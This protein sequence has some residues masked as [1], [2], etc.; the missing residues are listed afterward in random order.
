L[1][2]RNPAV[3]N[4]AQTDL[5]QAAFLAFFR[6]AKHCPITGK[7][8]G[9]YENSNQSGHGKKPWT[10]SMCQRGC[11]LCIGLYWAIKTHPTDLALRRIGSHFLEFHFPST[12]SVFRDEMRWKRF[13]SAKVDAS[14]VRE[15]LTD[16]KLGHI[17]VDSK[18]MLVIRLVRTRILWHLFV[19]KELPRACNLEHAVSQSNPKV[20]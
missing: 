17:F 10:K 19:S 13:L 15:I 8:P 9:I 12:R 4:D 5:L 14:L 11:G 20:V 6:M 18:R 2:I 7:G 1:S 16:P 3:S